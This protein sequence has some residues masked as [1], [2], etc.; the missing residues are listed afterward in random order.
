MVLLGY[1][2]D[3]IFS[4]SILSKFRI[5]VVYYEVGYLVYWDMKLRMWSSILLLN[6]NKIYEWGKRDIN[7]MNKWFKFL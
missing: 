7:W 3:W 1:G 2:I 4:Y 6:R 5:R